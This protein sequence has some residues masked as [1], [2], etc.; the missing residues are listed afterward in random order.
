VNVEGVIVS[1]N[2][3]HV[4]TLVSRTRVR[5]RITKWS[6]KRQDTVTHSILSPWKHMPMEQ[7]YT[8]S[9][10]CDKGSRYVCDSS[11]FYWV[12][13]TFKKTEVVKA[14]TYSIVA[15]TMDHWKA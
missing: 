9:K 15:T 13:L 8:T 3:G 7:W 12:D 14:Y 11:F 6:S 5:G 1:I 2:V 4:P 10:C